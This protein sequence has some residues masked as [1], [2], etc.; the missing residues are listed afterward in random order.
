MA[1][2]YSKSEQRLLEAICEY[3]SI[4]FINTKINNSFENRA[5]S[6]SNLTSYTQTNE[7]II[8][9]LLNKTENHIIE[10]SKNIE[11]NWE[12]I[13]EKINIQND[14]DLSEAITN[15]EYW[16]HNTRDLISVLSNDPYLYSTKP[17][18]GFDLWSTIK[19]L[20]ENF[21]PI[22]KNHNITLDIDMT[23]TTTVV[24]A[25]QHQ[26]YSILQGI[27]TNAIQFCDHEGTIK[28]KISP[29]NDSQVKVTISNSDTKMEDPDHQ[30]ETKN[31]GSEKHVKKRFGCIG[32]SFQLIQEMVK[33]N[34]SK[35]WIEKNPNDGT[36]FHLLFPTL[37]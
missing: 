9:E 15:L 37:K 29:N 34:N 5:K 10:F 36:T 13:K 16:V 33:L 19:Q 35:I 4:S 30:V 14:L 31:I 18:K 6:L 17:V 25:D 27:I 23:E 24:D 28:I 22:I 2:A 1:D 20:R 3:I 21:S 12:I 8:L 7:K 26:I 32:I 11:T